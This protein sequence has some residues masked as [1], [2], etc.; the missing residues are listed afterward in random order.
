VDAADEELTAAQRSAGKAAE[1]VKA[2]DTALAEAEKALAKI[3]GD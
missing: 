2:A 1:R 3:E